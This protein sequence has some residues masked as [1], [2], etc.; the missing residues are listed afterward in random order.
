MSSST[1]LMPPLFHCDDK[2]SFCGRKH[3]VTRFFGVMT[4]FHKNVSIFV[5]FMEFETFCQ[6]GNKA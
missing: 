4:G 5:R 2:E 6:E 3:I 1:V